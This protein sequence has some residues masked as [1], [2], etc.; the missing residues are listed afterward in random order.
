MVRGG[1]VLPALED[2]EGTIPSCGSLLRWLA[3]IFGFPATSEGYTAMIDEAL[4]V[5][6][7]AEGVRFVPVLAGYGT[8][9]WRPAPAGIEGLDLRHGRAHIV[10]AALEGVALQYRHILAGL[11]QELPHPAEV[12]L[13]GGAARSAGF[14]SVIASVSQLPVRLLGADPQN[15]ALRGAANCVWATLDGQ[16][17]SV[18]TLPAR[19]IEPDAAL[20]GIYA[21]LF[22]GYL[23]TVN[24]A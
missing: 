22:D 6:A 3:G 17:G 18:A 21:E 24:A 8:P 14:A 23:H 5:P 2:R 7:G 10:R 1:H 20:R 11:G 13:V 4:A 12:T 9:T 16:Y 15:A 19:S